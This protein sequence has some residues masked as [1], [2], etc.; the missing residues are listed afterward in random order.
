MKKLTAWL[1]TLVVLVAS[2]PVCFA[3]VT[4]E[5]T[6]VELEELSATLEVPEGF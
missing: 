5:K 1:V 2:I 6:K 3:D 4:T